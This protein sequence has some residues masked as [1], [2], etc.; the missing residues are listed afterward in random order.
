MPAVYAARS[1]DIPIVVVSYD[2]RPGRAS[3]AA[4]KYAAACAVAFPGS[5][6]PHA[7]LTGAPLRASILTVDRGRDREAARARVG[8]P[9]DRF[10]VA[11]MG[12]SLGSGVLNDAVTV[13][14]RARGDRRDLAVF[15]IAGERFAASMAAA[16]TGADGILYTVR[17]YEQDMP[18]VYA[19][20]DL[21]VGR[22]GASTVAEVAATGTPALLVPWAGSA[23]DHQAENVRWLS[24]QGS[25]ILVAE[26]AFTGDR[27]VAEV[28]RLMADRAALDAL[29]RAAYEAGA[30]HRE[31]RIADLIER[32]ARPGGS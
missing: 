23:E 28:D 29:G 31:G 22:G 9:S 27:L 5:P 21:L 1:L 12:G 8:V 26:S 4:A 20:A 24:D 3:R 17:G 2:K 7:T 11:V 32:V 16:T 6:L 25:A 19:A 13:L 14:V 15:H 18:A 30:I 10:L